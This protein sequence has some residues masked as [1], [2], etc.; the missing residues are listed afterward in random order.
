MTMPSCERCTVPTQHA[1]AV[2][3]DACMDFD[4]LAQVLSQWLHDHQVRVQSITV[5]R[6]HD[7]SLPPTITIYDH[8]HAVLAHGCLSFTEFEEQRRRNEEAERNAP[9]IEAW[10]MNAGAGLR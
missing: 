9:A 3:C 10:H 1:D 5:S 4:A 2:L 8:S 7:L 6:S